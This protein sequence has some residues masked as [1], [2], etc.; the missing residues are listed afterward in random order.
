MDC[1]YWSFVEAHPAHAPLP[2][3]AASE[4]IEILTW[5]HTGQQS[6]HAP[7][8]TILTRI[9]LDRLL[10]SSTS[11]PPF[12]QEE[13]HELTGLLRSLEGESQAGLKSFIHI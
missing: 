13:C 8:P 9:G 4:A 5:S 6:S 1:R 2:P 7:L 12:T 10:P 11:S 3:S